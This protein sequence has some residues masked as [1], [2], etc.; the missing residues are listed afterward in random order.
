MTK[1]TEVRCG[2]QEHPAADTPGGQ[3]SPAGSSHT[4]LR[5]PLLT[6]CDT[7]NIFVHVTRA[8]HQEAV[9][10][11]RSKRRP[12]QRQEAKEKNNETKGKFTKVCHVEKQILNI[13]K[14]ARA[15]REE[16]TKSTISIHSQGWAS[17]LLK[18]THDNGLIPH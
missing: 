9:D 16:G 1:D 15:E 3:N 2:G 10:T 6:I 4:E 7:V 8:A 18:K 13:Q 12:Q 17:L 5:F 14:G 11:E